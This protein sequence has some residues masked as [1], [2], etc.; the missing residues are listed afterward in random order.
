MFYLYLLIIFSAP[1]YFEASFKH[2]IISFVNISVCISEIW[3]FIKF[4]H[5]TVITSKEN[6]SLVFSN[7]QFSL[8]SV[9]IVFLSWETIQTLFI[10][11]GG[12][13]KVHTLSL[14]TMLN[15]LLAYF[16]PWNFL[17]QKLGHLSLKF[18]L[19]KS[20]KFK[21][22]QILVIETK[23][24]LLKNVVCVCIGNDRLK[25]HLLSM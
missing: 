1:D 11:I 24:N 6:D 5:N 8:F 20:N 3:L 17:L 15:R 21:S 12:P 22:S 7:I 9:F 4:D 2:H 10:W 18:S 16:F 14:V 25:F 13:S 19:I 23:L